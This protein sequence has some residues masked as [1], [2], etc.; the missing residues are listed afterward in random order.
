MH[1]MKKY[2]IEMN[3]GWKCFFLFV[4]LFFD[5]FEVMLLVFLV[6]YSYAFLGFF[7]VGTLFVAGMHLIVIPIIF[8]SATLNDESIKIH[9]GITCQKRIMYNRI[10]SM[11]VISC[12]SEYIIKG[13]PVYGSTA[14][15]IRYNDHQTIYISIKNAEQ[16]ISDIKAQL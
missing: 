16:F 14:V 5:A 8:A 9:C 1:L 4:A 7:I 2:T 6:I 13:N 3:R 11:N 12:E 15:K 10:L